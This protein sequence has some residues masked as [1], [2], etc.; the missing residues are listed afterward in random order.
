MKKL[1]AGWVECSLSDMHQLFTLQKY[2]KFLTPAR[3]NAF[4]AYKE[5]K[6]KYGDYK[7]RNNGNRI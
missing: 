1:T 7:K 4:L 5:L 3:E 6:R 2:N